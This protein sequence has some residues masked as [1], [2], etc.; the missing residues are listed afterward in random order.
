MIYR[1]KFNRIIFISNAILLLLFIA[2]SIYYFYI[3][4]YKIVL[5]E[6]YGRDRVV[7]QGIWKDGESAPLIIDGQV[8]LP[9]DVVKS[10][11]DPYI[12][13]D[14]ELKKVTIT[15]KDRVIRMQTESLDALINGK[16]MELEVPVTKREGIIYV[17]IEIFKS[18]YNIN[19]Q[20]IDNHNGAV[21]VIIDK[22]TE[23]SQ[24]VT[25]KDNVNK[26][27]VH[28]G[29]S[30]RTPLIRLMEAEEAK[31]L[32]IFGE[33][34]GWYLV[35]TEEG[36]FGNIQSKYVDAI[37]YPPVKESEKPDGK[38]HVPYTGKINM[39]FEM[40]YE[41]KIETSDLP[42]MSGL[43]VVSPTWLELENSK[44]DVKN[45]IDTGYLNW[46]HFKGLK[47]WALLANDFTDP[48]IT[49][50]FLNNTDSRDN[51]IRQVL[52]IAALYELDGI[53]I[54]FENIYKADRDALSQF[55][56]EFAPFMHEQ[57]L[58]VS[59]DVNIPDGSDNWSKCYDHKV[60]GEAVDY[61]IL[62]AYDQYY[63][64][65]GRAG[66]V[67]QLSWVE[68]NIIKLADIV[69]ISKLI[70]GIPFYT[71][72]WEKPVFKTTSDADKHIGV[73]GMERME[74]IIREFGAVQTWDAE[75]G[76]YIVTYNKDGKARIFW[77]EDLKSTDLK[78]SLVLKYNL[79][80]VASWSRVDSHPDIWALLDRN[81][82]QITDYSEWIP[83]MQ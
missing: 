24:V 27:R 76:Q 80:G 29:M 21:T 13:W 82:K 31:S 59:I 54:D 23:G 53:N 73:I 6:G 56:R 63:S 38:E 57:G 19:I 45:R 30:I 20:I 70:L 75:S 22:L 2:L 10:H 37:Y 83:Y 12:W 50:K 74:E 26:L 58:I 42:E 81:L 25:L 35:R 51:L 47:V 15:T 66:S 11:I 69:D 67:A 43:D 52:A 40:V 68:K 64:S 77:K 9:F 55:V 7:I 33:H 46:A 48:E 32:K 1:V 8:L 65:G 44:G 28:T 39:T 49:R 34:N 5:P 78:T 62:M 71:R 72:V 17:P 14:D 3:P 79:A 41:K 36:Y 16:P 60:L 18:F 61:L 4:N